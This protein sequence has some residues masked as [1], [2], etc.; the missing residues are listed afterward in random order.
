MNAVSTPQCNPTSGVYTPCSAPWKHAGPGSYRDVP[1][2][3]PNPVTKSNPHPRPLNDSLANAG[4][5]QAVARGMN[6][7]WLVGTTNGG[8]WRT[9]DVYASRTHWEPVTDGQPVNCVS[10]SAMASADNGKMVYA[11][12]GASTSGEWG[13]YGNVV[14]GGD[15]GGLMMSADG[16]TSWAMTTFP[17]NYFVTGI[18]PVDDSTLVVSARAHFTNDYNGGVWVSTD[19]GKTWTRTYFSPV[20]YLI[21]E[22]KSGIIYLASPQLHET[23]DTL[24]VYQSTDNGQTWMEWSTGIKFAGKQKPYYLTFAISTASSPPVVFLGAF[25][26]D[27]T[28]PPDFGSALFWR[29]Q[30]VK[31]STWQPISVNFTEFETGKPRT[32]LDSYGMAKD[33]LAILADPHDPNLLYVAGNGDAGVY[34]VQWKAQPKAKW[35]PM[36]GLDCVDRTYPHVDSRNYYWEPV[37]NNLILVSD[38]GIWMRMGP[39]KPGGRW[40]SLNGDIGAME[41]I[42]SGWDFR[43]RRWIA[44]AQ[45]NG[46]QVSDSDPIPTAEAKS[47]YGGDGSLVVVDNSYNP[48]RLWSSAEMGPLDGVFVIDNGTRVIIWPRKEFPYKDVWTMFYSPW[49]LNSSDPTR[50]IFWAN[51]TATPG[52]TNKTRISYFWE[53]KVPYGIKNASQAGPLTPL[54]PSGGT[55]FDF[56]A[57][58]YTAGKK[59]SSVIVAMN[60]THLKYRSSLTK[61]VLMER[62]LPAVFAY[63]FYKPPFSKD[64]GDGALTH[65]KT[66]SMAVLSS[67]SQTIA[68]TGWPN[69]YN[70]IGLEGIWMTTD[71]GMTWI[72][73][74]GNLLVATGTIGKMRPAGLQFVP[75]TKL[76]TNAL[77]VGTV[78]G[79]YVTYTDQAHRGIWSRLGSCSDMPV[80][81]ADGFGY[82]PYSDTLTV[83]TFGRGVYMIEKATEA[84]ATALKQQDQSKCDVPVTVLGENTAQ[85]SP[86]MAN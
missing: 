18:I 67:D 19:K 83:G 29:Q 68:V 37:K 54:L 74:T 42:S 56:V 9:S 17:A 53:I 41:F 30:G 73:V 26:R 33:R 78:S 2:D 35:T 22:P 1:P 13:T 66:T 61:G 75:M 31:G 76:N 6:N 70:N 7:D 3:Y 34:R 63:P 16:G 85:W 86:P 43:K 60:S 64:R 15:W 14:L 65:G 5:M 39:S 52:V 57:G 77:L 11:G 24:P 23:P 49:T 46:V 8:V 51:G 25:T 80:V 45:D 12:C 10:I 38:G 72:D 4:A 27:P 40:V 48:A 82:E 69:L 59:D 47:V 21:R 81:L 79:V 55:V 50:L 28:D 20:Y 36:Y 58:G 32:L 71:G 62:K 84:L 44:G